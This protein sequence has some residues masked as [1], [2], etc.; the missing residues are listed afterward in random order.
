MGLKNG[1]MEVSDLGE[2]Q[3]KPAL[4]TRLEWY[5]GMAIFHGRAAARLRYVKDGAIT[6]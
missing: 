2:L 3:T 6:A 1:E 4:R 5:A